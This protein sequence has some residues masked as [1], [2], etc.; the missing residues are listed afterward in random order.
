MPL[1]ALLVAAALEVIQAAAEARDV[2]DERELVEGSIGPASLLSRLEDER[3]AAGVWMLGAEEDFALP[4]EDNAEARA[5][6]DASVAEFRSQVLG[7]GGDVEEAYAPALDG[8]DQQLGEVR[9]QIE[10]FD[11]DRN[12]GNI[13]VASE[14]FD[15]YTALMNPFFEANVRV[16]R[17]IDDTELRQG[18]ELVDL[19]SRQTNLIAILTRDLLLAGIGG[20]GQVA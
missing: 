10:A 17:A 16:A 1:L 8:L 15:A 11:Q 4:V 19:S 3:N 7:L 12:L 13:E 18:A 9:D 5:A 14:T 20:D 6:T 2:R